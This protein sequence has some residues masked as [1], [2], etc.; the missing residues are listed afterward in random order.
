MNK[1]RSLVLL[2][3]GAILPSGILPVVAQES[4]ALKPFFVEI[5][6]H[7]GVPGLYDLVVPLEVMDKSREDLAD[8]RLFSAQGREIPYALRI[9]GEVDE[10][11]EVEARV[12]NQGRIGSTSEMSLD[13]GEDAGEHNE[14]EIETSG[15]NFRR[16]VEIEGGDSGKDWRTLKTGDVIFSFEAQNKLVESK[17]VSY[18]ASRYR[19]L[20]VRVFADEMSDKQQPPAISA[21]KVMM[22]LRE[23]GE[24]T[25]WKVAGPSYAFLMRNQNAPASAWIIDLGARVP[26]DRLTL[27]VNEDSFSRPFQIEAIDDP[28][29]IRLVTSGELTRRVG[30]ARQPVV[31]TF[32][33]EVYAQ[34][35]RLLVTDYS[36]QTLSITSIMPAAPA[37]QIVFELKETSA[38]LLRLY[39][40]D[41][42]STA[43]HYDFEK[44]LQSKLSTQPVRC[45]VGGVVENPGYKPEPLPLTERI[46]WL[47]YAVLTASSLALAIILISLTRAAL[48]AE[49][50]Q[51]SEAKP[52]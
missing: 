25:A 1:I 37:R 26:C 30:E 39:F 8:L 19:Y 5:T 35:L 47:I 33:K 3:A 49:P 34:K 45:E 27:E 46:P 52:S 12:F 42:K 28:Q 17:R 6:P 43:P 9:R 21:V 31:V 10:K 11:Q 51:A 16:R 4:Q 32:E 15:S 38:Q 18:P 24:L 29:N 41:A 36:N 13:L 2:V 50:E 22:A 20:R 40:G 48:R 23:K 7:A 44:E 14:V